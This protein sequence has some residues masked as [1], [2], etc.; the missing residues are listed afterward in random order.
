VIELVFLGT[1]SA[2]PTVRRNVSSLAVQLERET[3]LIDAGE[4]TQLQIL[5]SGIRR[6]RIDRILITHL[7]G[8]HFYGLIGLLTSFQL[9]RREEALSLYGPAGLSSYINFMKRLSQTD[10]GYELSIHELPD[11]LEPTRILDEP[12]YEVWAAPLKHRIYTLGFRV[13]EKELPGRF[14]AEKADVL[15]VPFGPERGR[16]IRGEDLRLPDGRR[17]RSSEL[18]GPPR[19]GAAFA[20]CTDTAYCEA[21]VELARDTDLLV[22]EATFDPSDRQNAQRTLHSTTEDAARVAREA[23]VRHLV[24][25][26]FSTRYMA[27]MSPIAESIEVCF[28]GALLA[29]DFM[30]IRILPEGAG[31]NLSDSRNKQQGNSR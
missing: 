30:K 25:T 29:R 12:E 17:V 22:H 26:H 23:G 15:G 3:L 9:N 7:H 27:D 13:L 1:S 6:G 28:P 16:L 5:R 18:V 8:D 24:L 19:K 10:F 31:L 4:G 21:S 20:F 11:L 14:D 2:T